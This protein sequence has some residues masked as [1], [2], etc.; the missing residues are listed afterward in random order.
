MARA[1]ARKAKRKGKRKRAK[2]KRGP[3][4]LREQAVVISRPGRK[5]RK[6][7]RINE[8][9]SNESMKAYRKGYNCMWKHCEPYMRRIKLPKPGDFNPNNVHQGRLWA[10][11]RECSLTGNQASLLLEKCYDAGVSEPQLRQ[12]KKSLSYAYCLT[13]G[14]ISRNYPKVKDMWDSFGDFVQPT[15][16]NKPDRIPTPE[17]LRD[18]FTT[19]WHPGCGM[20]LLDWSVALLITWDWAIAGARSREDL[21]RIKNSIDHD[22]NVQEGYGSTGYVEGRSKLCG[23]KRG[24]R[25]W[26]SWRICLCGDKHEPVPAVFRHRFDRLGNPTTEPTWCTNCPVC[27]MELISL[28]QDGQP[29]MYPK[30]LSGKKRGG[31]FSECNNVADCPARANEWMKI[32]GIDEDFSS[33]AGRK[34]LARWLSKV[35]VDYEVGFEIHGDLYSVWS[36]DYQP[37]SDNPTGFKK[38]K[39]SMNPDKC[40]AAYKKLRI[41]FGITKKK[42]NLSRMEKLLL[43]NLQSMG[44]GA[45]AKKIIA[46]SS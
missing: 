6:A 29:R 44:K 28:L 17:N 19:A 15:E 11:P 13:S 7:I 3:K 38:R 31:R 26:R 37:D 35:D 40:L 25:P 8:F 36:Q 45:Q 30:W 27:C 5:A 20:S 46:E 22:I 2:I 43:L 10:L 32:Q 9:R 12:V 23:R 1:R 4:S 42:A 18:S 14:K 41:F 16:S 24:T 33:N 39:Q 34:S 21:K